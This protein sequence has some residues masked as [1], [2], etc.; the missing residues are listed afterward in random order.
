MMANGPSAQGQGFPGHEDFTP[1]Q[2]RPL[3]NQDSCSP[4]TGISVHTPLRGVQ[5]GEG[6]GSRVT[7]MERLRHKWICPRILGLHHGLLLELKSIASPSQLFQPLPRSPG[8]TRIFSSHTVWVVPQLAL[9][10]REEA[11][12]GQGPSPGG[13]RE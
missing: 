5:R 2:Q 8:D 4:D 10:G 13:T 6:H 12:Q 7:A 11:G 9:P 1:G 3:V